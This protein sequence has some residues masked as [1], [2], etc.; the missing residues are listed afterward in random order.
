MNIFDNIAFPLSLMKVPKAE[1]VKRVH[2]V[3]N[4]NIDCVL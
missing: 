3:F 4:Y 2:E 1:V